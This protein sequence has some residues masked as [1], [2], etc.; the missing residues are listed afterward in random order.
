MVVFVLEYVAD[1]ISVKR[2]AGDIRLAN[3]TLFKDHK[4]LLCRAPK[5]RVT[6][7]KQMIHLIRR[8]ALVCRQKKNMLLLEATDAEIISSEPEDAIIVFHDCHNVF[9]WN[10]VSLVVETENLFVPQN[11]ELPL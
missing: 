3:A 10:S 9:G 8:Q 1:V 5:D 11:P 7:N 2:C 6:V 4:P